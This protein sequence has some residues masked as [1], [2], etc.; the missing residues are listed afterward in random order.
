MKCVV[1]LA[2]LASTAAASPEIA[3]DDPT[4]VVVVAPPPP[5]PRA[6][7]AVIELGDRFTA[8]AGFGMMWLEVGGTGGSGMAIQPTLQRTFDR[9]ELQGELLLAD[10]QH[11]TGMAAAGG[12]VG[13]LGA[14]ARYQ[15]GRIRV[16]HRMTLD[17]V[18]EAGAGLQGIALDDGGTQLRS[19]LELGLGL[20]MLT[21]VH[22][23]G[24]ARA[25]LGMEA[26][27]RVLIAPQP[28]ARPDLGLVLTFGIPF[29]R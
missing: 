4:P 6:P 2:A 9:V 3:V 16:E 10:W 8:F 13:R 29:G 18:L 21:D 22:E 20:R 23:H 17:L 25:F 11:G 28:D 27:L 5:P 19:D 12:I 14:E 7:A 24:P 15:A 26:M 1:L